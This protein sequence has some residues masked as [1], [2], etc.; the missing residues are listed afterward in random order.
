MLRPLLAV[1]V[2]AAFLFSEVLSSPSVAQESGCPPG[3]LPFPGDVQCAPVVDQTA[4]PW[5]PGVSSDERTPH[6]GYNGGL[7]RYKDGFLDSSQ[8][9][10]L[11]TG[12]AVYPEGL[13]TDLG[14]SWGWR[15]CENNDGVLEWCE[16]NNTLFTTATNRSR[17]TMEITVFYWRQGN[18]ELKLWDFSCSAQYPCEHVQTGELL[19]SPNFVLSTPLRDNPC[20]MEFDLL[21]GGDWHHLL[22]YRNATEKLDNG[23]P[24]L[25]RNVAK[26]ANFC[27]Y[28]WDTVY[29]HEYRADA[30]NCALGGCFNWAAL[31]EYDPIEWNPGS[32][33][34]SKLG[35]WQEQ[36]FLAKAGEPQGLLTPETTA[37][38]PTS[39]GTDVPP[40][41]GVI[42]HTTP[43]H[44]WGRGTYLD[45][46]ADGVWDFQDPDDDQDGYTD[47]NEAGAPLCVG[48]ANDDEKVGA[49]LTPDDAAINDGCPT[50][51]SP[52]TVCG[53][54]YD[55]DGDG[56]VNDGCPQAGSWSEAQFNV[57]TMSVGRCSYTTDAPSRVWPSDLHFGVNG[58]SVQRVDI[59]DLTSFL[60]PVKRV[61]TAPGQP[62]FDKR[63][64]LSPGR[65]FSNNMI[66]VTDILALLAAS[67]TGYPPML[68]GVRA[69]NGPRCPW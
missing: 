9:S 44:T 58:S 53:L 6:P 27:T 7:V 66:N 40:G 25:W 20:Y 48:S 2:V 14:T 38:I 56:F 16:L 63:W 15:D 22:F 51:G 18:A 59:Y 64:D 50:V 46:D 45:S 28:T 49:G 10:E 35:F 54:A 8:G 29:F 52:E 30:Y 32:T 60:A 55:E 42:S 61:D 5:V 24:P 43:N 23:S 4:K 34:I 12:V 21:P 57:G 41:W 26:L 62:G 39:W 37:W 65:G 36:L 67:S 13:G 3:T 47:L 11:Y 19:P 17:F 1:V 33:P 69:F 68:G 31:L